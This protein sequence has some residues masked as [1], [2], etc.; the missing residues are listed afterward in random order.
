[1]EGEEGMMQLFHGD[2]LEE[3]KQIGEG[4][5]D[6]VLMDPP[7]SSGGLFG[8]CAKETA[9]SDG[10]AGGTAGEAAYDRTRGG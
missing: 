7:Y 5:V 4:S 3:L 2:C 6:M 10:K 8:G 9:A 1:M